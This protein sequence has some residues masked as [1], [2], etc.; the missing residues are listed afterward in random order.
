MCTTDSASFMSDCKS[1]FIFLAEASLQIM[2]LTTVITLKLSLDISSRF[3]SIFTI[4]TVPMK[5]DLK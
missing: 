2:S 3:S 4:T 1:N 5:A